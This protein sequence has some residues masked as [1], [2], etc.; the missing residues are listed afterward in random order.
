MMD[1]GVKLLIKKEGLQEAISILSEV[2]TP[3]NCFNCGSS[4]IEFGFGRRKPSKILLILLSTLVFVPF[5]NINQGYFCK[6]CGSK[7]SE[8][9]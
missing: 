5:L 9:N 1:S 7:V 4:N 6:E 8:S 3:K 2:Q